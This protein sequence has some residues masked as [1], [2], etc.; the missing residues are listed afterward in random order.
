[1]WDDG[2]EI[3]RL[4]RFRRRISVET[5]VSYA[6]VL[7]IVVLH[8][9]GGAFPTIPAGHTEGP[10]GA[11]GLTACDRPLPAHNM[12]VCGVRPSA[13]HAGTQSSGFTKSK[14]EPPGKE[15]ERLPPKRLAMTLN[16][17][18]QAVQA[19][20]SVGPAARRLL[21]SGGSA[22]GGGVGGGRPRDG[23]AGDGSA[24]GGDAAT[25]WFGLHRAVSTLSAGVARLLAPIASRDPPTNTTID[26]QNLLNAQYF[27]ALTVRPHRQLGVVL[28][29]LSSSFFIRSACLFLARSGVLFFYFCT[30]GSY[31]C[32]ACLFFFLSVILLAS[33]QRSVSASSLPG[34]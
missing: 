26:L 17:R 24:A 15:E 25:G 11:E 13:H 16:W 32:I 18:P 19:G 27:G 20:K 8:G 23:G 22:D 5:V 10:E 7:G 30:V 12:A 29:T 3:G 1:M 21:R 34:L 33:A 14:N 6:F 2:Y 9:V 28:F 4:R 31:L